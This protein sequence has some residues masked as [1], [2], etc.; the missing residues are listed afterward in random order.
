MNSCTCMD[1]I[2][3][4]SNF[5]RVDPAMNSSVPAARARRAA[6]GSERRSRRHL[7]TD[8]HYPVTA[9]PSGSSRRSTRRNADPGSTAALITPPRL[10]NS[11]TSTAP[12]S[13]LLRSGC[14]G[15]LHAVPVPVRPRRGRELELDVCQV[16]TGASQA[17]LNKNDGYPPRAEVAIWDG[18]RPT[19]RL[20][21]LVRWGWSAYPT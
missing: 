12:T 11:C 17:V 18:V 16:W 7:L 4:L 20:S 6:P 10:M 2:P 3:H 19:K 5:W 9:L 21:D 8:R 15:L 14:V 1:P 13:D